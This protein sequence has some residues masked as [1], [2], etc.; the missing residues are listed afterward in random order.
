MTTDGESP[1]DRRTLCGKR[2]A[3]TAFHSFRN[4]DGARVLSAA[5]CLSAP[6]SKVSVP[7]E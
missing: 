7:H 3:G 6:T 5:V 1:E 2:R 4:N